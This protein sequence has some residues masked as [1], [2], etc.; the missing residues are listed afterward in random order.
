MFGYCFTE[1]LYTFHTSSFQFFVISYRGKMCFTHMSHLLRWELQ[2]V[3]NVRASSLRQEPIS[4]G[5]VAAWALKRVLGASRHITAV[6]SIRH[7]TGGWDTSRLVYSQVRH[8]FP[9]VSVPQSTQIL[10]FLI[11]VEIRKQNTLESF[12][13]W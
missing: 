7:W 6:R 12:K 13:I 11:K 3:E 2:T 4:V 10:L 1:N 9:A 5:F 8:P